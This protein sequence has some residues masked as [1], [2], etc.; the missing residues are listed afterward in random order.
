MD[1]KSRFL[2]PMLVGKCLRFWTTTITLEL[3]LLNP[4]HQSRLSKFSLAAD[5][6]IGQS[7][8]SPIPSF[9][10]LYSLENESAILYLRSQQLHF[11]TRISAFSYQAHSNIF[12]SLASI[13]HSQ[14]QPTIDNH[15][16]YTTA[17]LSL[18]HAPYTIDYVAFMTKVSR[19]PC[20][21]N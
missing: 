15:L 5:L 13:S 3:N 10:C 4:A 21:S 7:L 19:K 18:V 17:A 1:P 14:N 2:G 9:H 12:F 20:F 6:P 8:S 11:Q 16:S